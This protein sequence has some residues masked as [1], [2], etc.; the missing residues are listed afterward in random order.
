MKESILKYTE[1]DIDTLSD[2]ELRVLVEKECAVNSEV[3]KKSPRGLLIF[4]LFDEKVVPQLISPHHIIDH[5]IETTPLC[6]PHRD[7]AKR[8]EGL[9]ERFESF[10]LGKEL[11]N[12]Y[13]ELNDPEIQ[14]KLLLDQVAKR[15]QGDEEAHPLDEEFIEAI[16]QGMPPAGGLG[17]G[18]DRLTMFLTDSASIRDVLYFPLMKG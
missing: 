7:P 14:R 4:S 3:I 18:M 9:V 5:P 8:K 1:I 6:K 17:I 11:C 15:E 2:A 10:L 16:C 12:A 13:T